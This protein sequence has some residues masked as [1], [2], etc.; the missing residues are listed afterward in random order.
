MAGRKSLDRITVASPRN[1]RED[2]DAAI[3]VSLG[4]RLNLERFL[5]WA[6]ERPRF[7]YPATVL[8]SA[9]IGALAGPVAALVVA[10]YCAYGLTVLLRARRTRLVTKLRDRARHEVELLANDVRAGAAPHTAM[11]ALAAGMHD[12]SDL[13]VA[14]IRER[15]RTLAS[16]IESTGAPAADLLDRLVTDLR[17]TAKTEAS[18]TANTAGIRA[19][20][21]MLALLPLTGPILGAAIGADPLTVLLHTPVGMF[22]LVGAIGLQALGLLWSRRIRLAVET[23]AVAV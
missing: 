2:T 13:V 23:Q 4:A 22:C 19:S 7:A 21:G 17:S 9:A 3:P 15:L 6:Q 14:G 1:A 20:A 16:V 11:V 10:G 12:S 5:R 18:L 8:I